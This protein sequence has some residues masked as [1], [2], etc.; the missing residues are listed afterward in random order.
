VLGAEVTRASIKLRPV[1]LFLPFLS[2]E[3]G[4][5]NGRQDGLD[6]VGVHSLGDG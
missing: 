2:G 5:D 6:S 3:N 1:M 4:L